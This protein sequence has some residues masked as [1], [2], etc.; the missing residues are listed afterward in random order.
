MPVQFFRNC[1]AVS[2]IA[3]TATTAA[4]SKT[5]IEALA[6]TPKKSID[7][8][9]DY[10][11][12]LPRPNVDQWD[13]DYHSYD[14]FATPLV[15]KT[16]IGMSYENKG[17]HIWF[18]SPSARP[19]AELDTS[20]LI[21]DPTRLIGTWRVVSNRT[22][23]F[24]DS[25]SLN[26]PDFSRNNTLVNEDNSD[27]AFLQISDKQFQLFAKAEGKK[28][29]KRKA[30]AHYLLEGGRYLLLYKLAKTGA[31][32]SQAG[33]DREGRLVLHSAVVEERKVPNN[34]IVYIA[35]VNQAI[36]ER[37]NVQP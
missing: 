36:Y 6:A 9:L 2:L 26:T 5:E 23:K 12:S 20:M 21:T 3:V 7:P 22:M 28:A 13:E 37:V 14:H 19:H 30:N 17:V 34:Y 16:Q 29:F 11:I 15:K 8:P 10:A 31:A 27:D 33:I 25:A 4:Q 24:Q 35:V 32:I 18:C 1:I